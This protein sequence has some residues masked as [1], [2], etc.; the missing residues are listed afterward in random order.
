MYNKYEPM[1][2][3]ENMK[4]MIKVGRYPNKEAMELKITNFVAEGLITVEQGC[5]LKELLDRKENGELID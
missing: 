2:W 3:F 5:E 1:N 4:K